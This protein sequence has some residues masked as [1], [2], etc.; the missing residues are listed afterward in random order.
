MAEYLR[1]ENTA[2]FTYNTDEA[3]TSIIY[4]VN[5][6][7]NGKTLEYDELYPNNPGNFLIELTEESSRYDRDLRIDID[8]IFPTRYEQDH[9]YITLVR[10][11]VTVTDINN[12]FSN[13]PQAEQYDAINPEYLVI[14]EKKARYLIQSI[15]NDQFKFEYKTVGAYGSNTDLLHLGQRIESFDK[16]TYNDYVV[17]D[18]T[19][20]PVI[21]ELGATI[22]VAPSKYAIKVV[23][24]GVNISEW[25]D[26]NPLNNPAYFGKD[27]AYLVRGEYGW[28]ELPEDIKV[29]TYE[30]INDFVCNDYIYRN[31][32][33]KSIQNDAFNIQF[34]DGMLNGTGNLY[35]DALLAPYKS[36]N[37][38]AI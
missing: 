8:L 1:T 5:D 32:G 20:D 28:R 10:P 2:S 11:F 24:E 15:T 23:A 9:L 35:V 6:S 16:I 25:V 29:A 22:A 19:E 34:A 14:L 4:S 21:D 12:Y 3:V 17:Y 26:Q 13:T 37:L 27:A 33:L 30:L 7:L 18:P 36:W 38:K 31:K